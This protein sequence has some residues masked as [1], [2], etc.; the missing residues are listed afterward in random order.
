MSLDK[1]SLLNRGKIESVTL[2]DGAVVHLRSLSEK[3]RTD[4]ELAITE[5][6]KT[7]GFGSNFRR[8]LLVKS[9]CD[10]KGQRLFEDHEEDTLG[11]M[12]AADAVTLFDAAWKLA[13]FTREE[14][15]SLEKK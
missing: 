9:L 12:E 5:E 10:D 8:R 11:G 7:G 13:A 1:A 3:E 6:H 4:L 15:K 14:V 2:A